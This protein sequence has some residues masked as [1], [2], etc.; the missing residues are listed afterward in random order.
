MRA[1]VAHAGWR[2][3]T[4]MQLA[5]AGRP[6]DGPPVAR[7]ERASGR[8]RPAVTMRAPFGRRC[9]GRIP[10]HRQA[11][12]RAGGRAGPILPAART[13]RLPRSSSSGRALSRA[14]ISHTLGQQAGRF[15]ATQR[16]LCERSTGRSLGKR[17]RHGSCRC[18]AG[19]W[20]AC[21]LLLLVRACVCA[22][23]EQT[24]VPCA[25]SRASG[26]QQHRRQC[27]S[28]LRSVAAFCWHFDL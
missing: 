5:R 27:R 22:S 1:S 23:G 28:R 16:R 13:V 25:R 12:G 19:N 14:R 6:A 7:P 18:N 21:V 24:P 2:G 26:N 3:P 20:L 11:G 9:G 10:S 17:R 8:H 15:G 4:L